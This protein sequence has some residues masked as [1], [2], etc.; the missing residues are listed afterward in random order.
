M[1]EGDAGAEAWVHEK[2]LAVLVGKALI[3]AAAIRR[4]ATWSRLE[5]AERA[6]ADRAADYLL[7][8]AAHLDYPTALAKPAPGRDDAILPSL[9]ADAGLVVFGTAGQP[10]PTAGRHGP[11]ACPGRRPRWSEARL[12]RLVRAPQRGPQG[13]RAVRG[14]RR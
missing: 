10:P 4:T 3:V 11:A 8:K 13:D 9:V 2:A 14:R 1:A 5:E 7:N 6:N 12:P